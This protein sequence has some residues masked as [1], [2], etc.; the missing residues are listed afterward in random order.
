MAD[1]ALEF[2]TTI[3]QVTRLLDGLDDAALAGPTP[4]AEYTLAQLLNHF[5]GLATAFTGAAKGER[6]PHTD[7]PPGTP[8]TAL[9]ADWQRE[10]ADRLRLLAEAWSAPEAWQGEA[11][12]GGVTL[13]A[14]IM[15]LVALNEV[16]VHGWDLAKA[17][18]RSYTLD[19]A[20][21]AAL[22]AFVS[23]DADDQAAR[24][25][26]YGPVVQA[27]EDADP[28]ERFIAL[29]GRDPRWKR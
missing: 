10:L 21:L 26:V 11:T 2:E 1:D 22:T 20:V 15:G 25:G 24:E 8:P 7:T 12:A 17:T 14:R 23:H 28:L 27:P 13:P 6:G 18:G 16:A 9:G 4:C 19:P 29:T 3:T 5:L